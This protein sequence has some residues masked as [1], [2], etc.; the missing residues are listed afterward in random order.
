MPFITIGKIGG[1]DQA[2]RG[3]REQFALF[4]LA[5]GGFDKLGRIP[6]AE[7]NLDAFG[8]EPPL[9]QVNLCGLA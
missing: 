1:V 5:G 9:E 7:I 6:F 4:A 3:R 2:E 8:F